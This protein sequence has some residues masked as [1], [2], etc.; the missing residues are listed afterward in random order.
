MFTIRDFK[1]ESGVYLRLLSKMYFAR[2][3]WW[4]LLP[5]LV[6]GACGWAMSDARWLIVALM[7]AFV[8]YPMLLALI[9]I[10]YAFIAEARWNVMEKTA[11]VDD[12]GI[13]LTFT[14]ERM[15]PHLIA[16]RDISHVERDARHIYFHLRTRKYT[17]LILP[18]NILPQQDIYE[19]Q[20]LRHVK[21][22]MG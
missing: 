22:R 7:V 2:N 19:T 10:N 1:V 14:H 5:L 20:L 16:W 3:W 6:C 9:Y 8:M 17:F 21:N 18:C 12:E 11:V 15:K 4:Y 13:R